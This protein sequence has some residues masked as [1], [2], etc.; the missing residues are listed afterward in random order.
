MSCPPQGCARGFIL[1][2]AQSLVFK[3]FDDDP[4]VR[5]KSPAQYEVV[6]FLQDVVYAAIS[7]QLEGLPPG[8]AAAVR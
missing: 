5:E 1:L 8:A 2:N 7:A 3:P 6:L 4:L